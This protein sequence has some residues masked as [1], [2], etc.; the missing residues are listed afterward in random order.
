[1]YIYIHTYNQYKDNSYIW[2]H[3]VLSTFSFLSIKL[4]KLAYYKLLKG[5]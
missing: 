2:V 5:M 4:L 3:D 1:M